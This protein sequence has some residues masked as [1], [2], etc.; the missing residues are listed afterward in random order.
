MTLESRIG[1]PAD[2]LERVQ[3]LLDYCRD[4]HIPEEVAQAAARYLKTGASSAEF[5]SAYHALSG[6][7]RVDTNAAEGDVRGRFLMEALS[8]A[9]AELDAVDR[10]ILDLCFALASITVRQFY[11]DIGSHDRV[12]AACAYACERHTDETHV[13]QYLLGVHEPLVLDADGTPNAA[14]SALLSFLPAQLPDVWIGMRAFQRITFARQMRRLGSPYAEM[15]TTQMLDDLRD[16]IERHW[17]YS[18]RE[19][20]DF[21]DLDPRRYDEWVFRLAETSSSN[22]LSDWGRTAILKHLR[23]RNSPRYLDLALDFARKPVAPKDRDATLQCAGLAVAYQ[24]DRPRYHKLLVDALLG[25]S[26]P[27]ITCAL[28]TALRDEDTYWTRVCFQRYL[29]DMKRPGPIIHISSREMP[30]RTQLALG[31]LEPG[32][33]ESGYLAS[34]RRAPFIVASWLLNSDDE[35]LEQRRA[36]ALTLLTHRNQE[37][38]ELA[39]SWLS[40]QGS[41]VVSDV[42]PLLHSR[43]AATR[44]HA[45]RI[46]AAIGDENAYELLRARLATER[47]DDVRRVLRI[48]LPANGSIGNA[49]SRT[50]AGAETTIEMSSIEISTAMGA[51][52]QSG[53]TPSDLLARISAL[54]AEAEAAHHRLRSA[55][56]PIYTWFELQ[57]APAPRWITGEEVPLLVLDYLLRAQARMRE[58]VLALPV[59]RALPLIDRMSAGEFALALAE[60]WAEHAPYKDIISV[61]LA[62]ALGDDRTM[63]P[64]LARKVQRGI[65]Y[66]KSYRFHNLRL[67]VLV[68]LASDALLDVVWNES[69]AGK[70]PKRITQATANEIFA[71][72]AAR[73]GDNLEDLFDAHIGLGR[74]SQTADGF[75]DAYPGYHHQKDYGEKRHRLA[76]NA[77]WTLQI[78]DDTDAEVLSA[79][80]PR[81]IDS[82]ARIRAMYKQIP[83]TWGAVLQDVFDNMLSHA[84]RLETALATQRTWTVTR[85]A[86]LFLRH[87]FMHII[88]GGLIWGLLPSVRSESYTTLFLLLPD[89]TLRTADGGI[90]ALPN[91]GVVRLVHPLELNEAAHD[92][93]M[94]RLA[95]DGVTPCIYQLDR[96]VFRV[97]GDQH[98]VYQVQTPPIG[99][100]LPQ[101]HK[102]SLTYWS[103]DIRASGWDIASAEPGDQVQTAWKR[104]P[105]LGIEAAL[106]RPVRPNFDI[107]TP[108]PMTLMFLPLDA[109]APSTAD[110]RALATDDARLLS[111]GDVPPIAY[112][113][114]LLDVE[115]LVAGGYY[116]D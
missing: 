64:V 43:T 50:G 47:N 5:I 54:V 93:W 27:L 91:D 115:R 100:Y 9:D 8:S 18:H 94:S 12:Q 16:E 29:A 42:A 37:V 112:S 7:A 68:P 34:G 25:S 85:W 46:L 106:Q 59:E 69:P 6:Q 2:L 75:Y 110:R 23:E 84:R 79:A 56:K 61:M 14:S 96:P 103:D 92:R 101:A 10:R 88:G 109:V 53:D 87:P 58:P 98:Q 38:R 105:T 33:L 13:W 102:N 80:I 49:T 62:A 67:Q 65:P 89:C 71:R 51:G 41:D 24:A 36:Y 90:L 32:H 45:A 63:A 52:S 81:P 73:R 97:P 108:I 15:I 44:L 57:S 104:F 40:L 113:E 111:F 4:H 30:M 48:A 19:V 74:I 86:E 78:T 35:S 3:M 11:C 66:Q 82:G 107:H 95:S 83:Y 21:Y 114:A 39:I 60:A 55:E 31:H 76:I 26:Q 28:M 77:D 99:W 17:L 70:E 20:T 22:A 1:M 116:H 72:V